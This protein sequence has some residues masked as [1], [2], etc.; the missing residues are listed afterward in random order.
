MAFFSPKQ[1]ANVE[2]LQQRDDRSRS[3]DAENVAQE[4]LRERRYL[5]TARGFAMILAASL[6]TNILMVMSLA[7]LTPLIRVQPYELTFSDKKSQTVEIE[8]LPLGKSAINS[9][10]EYMLRRYV[11]ARHTV[12][13]DKEEM[14]DR[15]GVGGLVQILSSDNV[16]DEFQQTAKVI[17]DEVFEA[18]ET[19]FVRIDSV[20]PYYKDGFWLVNLTIKKT[21]PEKEDD[22]IIP[23][24]A[25][26]RVG[27]EPITSTW[28]KRL[29]NP[30]GFKVLTY[31]FETK[32]SFDQREQ[33]RI[34]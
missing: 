29:N 13:A 17:L 33:Q 5:W 25:T 3:K 30:V 21:S 28:E 9:I 10:S 19:R 8:P 31:G 20:L 12:T 15:W 18:G 27:F 34:K 14:A 1:P 6:I 11:T 2:N 32:A 4:N 24:V 7:S 26:V 22:E 16:F 23:Y